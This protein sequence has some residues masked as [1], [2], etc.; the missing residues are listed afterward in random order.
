M[1]GNYSIL[2]AVLFVS[3]LGSCA[4]AP[5]G[6]QFSAIRPV[7]QDKALVYLY[8]PH[9][10]SNR[11][12]IFPVILNNKKIADLGNKGFFVIELDAGTYSI[13]SDT[14]SIDHKMAVN[15]EN[16]TITFVR[17]IV[18][19]SKSIL[20]AGFCISIRFEIVNESNALNE[21]KQTREEVK[22]VYFK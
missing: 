21:L 8:R 1:M 22:R 5:S 13:H 12:A 14:P 2:L 16:G 15:L 7:K 19:D 11:N 17:L 9:D 10:F 18:D 6:E 3:L 20:C 4:S